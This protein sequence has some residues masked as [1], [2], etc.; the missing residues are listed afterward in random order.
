[1]NQKVILEK[2]SHWIFGKRHNWC[3]GNISYQGLNKNIQNKQLSNCDEFKNK[4]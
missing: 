1:M 3:S 4:I 2:R